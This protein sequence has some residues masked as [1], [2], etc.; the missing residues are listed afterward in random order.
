MGKEITL[1]NYELLQITSSLAEFMK[2]ELPVKVGWN[3]KKNMTNIQSVFKSFVDFE[4]DLVSKYAVKIDG[5]IQYKEDGQPK[6][7][8]KTETEFNEKHNE[9]VNCEST[10]DILP[11]KLSD[12]LDKNIKPSLLFNLDFMIE[13]DLEEEIKPENE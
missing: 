10:V 11:I 4:N 7:Y 2:I 12:I 13:D 6:L 9:L 5:K 8:P 3:V 1:K